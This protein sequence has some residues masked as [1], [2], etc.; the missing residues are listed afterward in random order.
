MS[1]TSTTERP[2]IGADEAAM[3]RKIGYGDGDARSATS[4]LIDHDIRVATSETDAVEILPIQEA[5]MRYDWVQDLMFN[6]I[7]PDENEL[8]RQSAELLQDPIGRFVYVHDGAKLRHPIQSFTVMS[9][10]QERQFT[11]NIT[12]IG[13]DAEVEII[14]GAAV[15]PNV[16]A[17]HH[18]SIDETYLRDGARMRS[19]SIERWGVNMRVDSYSRSEIGTGAEVTSSQI[20]LAALRRHHS[21]T[22]MRLGADALC[23]DQAII[24]APKG[25]ERTFDTEVRLSAPGAR[26]EHVARMVSGGGRIVNN[27]VL[28]GETPGTNGF[29][30]CDGL[31]LSGE[32][33]ISATPALI[34]DSAEAQLSHEASVGMI[35]SEKLAYLM[36]AGLGEDRAR[37]LIVQGFLSLNDA[38]I[39]ADIRAQVA[40]MVAAAKSGGM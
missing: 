21:D 9:R 18:V 33:Q 37:D 17:G 6:Q 26:S 16:H 30:G 23:S 7:A 11:H 2:G 27:S 15:P 39:P 3:L 25:T 4:I 19:V 38:D 1:A 10:P 14:S 32:G 5:L 12:V 31:M 35:S 13:R 29:L 28:I 40:D 22:K 36:A 24:F 34:A 20:M 8:L